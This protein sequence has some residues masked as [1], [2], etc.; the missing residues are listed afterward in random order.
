MNTLWFLVL[1]SFACRASLDELQAKRLMQAKTA[2][3]VHKLTKEFEQ[4]REARLS[5]K[6]Q[7][8]DKLPPTR[9][10]EVL[11]L[12]Q[13]VGAIER[14]RVLLAQKALDKICGENVRL[15]LRSLSES[16]PSPT[17]Y[18]SPSCRKDLKSLQK[19]WTYRMPD[20]WSGS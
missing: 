8:R 11:A 6:F 14:S 5:C 2:D 20:S 16:P 18:L 4:L 13:R 1:F 10:F 3:S 12:E 7:L 19:V 9:C 15:Q 17:S